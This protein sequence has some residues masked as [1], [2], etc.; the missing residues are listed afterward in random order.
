M[1]EK[2]NL[3]AELREFLSMRVSQVLGEDV[4]NVANLKLNIKEVGDDI[5]CLLYAYQVNRNWPHIA[6][7][8]QSMTGIERS[9]TYKMRDR[10]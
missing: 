9:T 6:A 5:F 2:I 8:M 10:R 7:N 4:D 3:N 1:E